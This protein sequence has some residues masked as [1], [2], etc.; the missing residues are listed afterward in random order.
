MQAAPAR[1]TQATRSTTTHSFVRELGLLSEEEI[2]LGSAVAALRAVATKYH[3][4][5]T[6]AQ[7]DIHPGRDVSSGNKNDVT[8]TAS[9]TAA[10]NE[11]RRIR[12]PMITPMIAGTK[13]VT[14][15]G[16]DSVWLRNSDRHSRHGDAHT[17]ALTQSVRREIDPT[18]NPQV[19]DHATS[20]TASQT[21][22][23]PF[24]GVSAAP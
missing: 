9:A 8:I 24:V 19:H 2:Q 23:S 6:T 4:G 13:N 12:K 11:I 17:A 18:T 21:S 22:S 16:R 7:A 15:H 20:S 14:R 1:N 3:A 10:G 5:Q